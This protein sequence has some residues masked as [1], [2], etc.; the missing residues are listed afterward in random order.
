MP[1]G[2]NNKEILQ[3]SPYKH[4]YFSPT[5]SAD[6]CGKTYL[7]Y[8]CMLRSTSRADLDRS[9]VAGVVSDY[10]GSCTQLM[11]HNGRVVY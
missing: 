5:P 1:E 9:T 6:L 11:E 8:L 2:L 3:F 10:S 7:G 4:A